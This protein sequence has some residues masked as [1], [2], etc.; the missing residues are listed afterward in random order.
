MLQRVKPNAGLLRVIAAGM[1]ATALASVLLL[2]A[3]P[4]HDRVPGASAREARTPVLQAQA[5][6]TISSRARM[7]RVP[8]SFLGLSTEYWAMPVFA[9]H[10]APLQR[11]LSLVHVRGD[12][13]LVLRIGGDSADHAFWDPRTRRM[14]RWVFALTPAWLRQTRILV[15]RARV[16]LILDLNLITG[17]PLRAA[18]WARAAEANLPG[19]AIAGF[20]IGNEADIYSRRYWLAAMSR[21]RLSA[22][23]IPDRLSASAY[24]QDFQSYARALAQVAPGVPLVGPAVA[25]PVRDVSWISSLLASEHPRLG[26]VSAHRYPFSACAHP[27]SEN[28]PT[29][30]RLLSERATAGLA[31]SV[32]AAARHAHRAG[33]P[34]RLTELNS[35]TC[36]GRPGVSDTF[37]TALWA[38]DA[39]FEL[40][41]AGVDGANVHVRAGAANAAFTLGRRG[42]GA[43]P[44]LYG[45]ILFARALGPDAQLIGV[46]VHA[47]RSTHL[48]VWAVRV[49]GGALH[50]LLID[51]GDDPARVALRLP[52]TGPA[53]VE[54]LL[55]PSVGSR[56][57]V[58]LDGQQ[59]GRKGIWRGRPAK[60]TITPG[61]HGYEV[62]VAPVSAALL[63]V[64]LRPGALAVNVG[65]DRSTQ[66]RG[67]NAATRLVRTGGAPAQQNLTVAGR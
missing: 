11:V 35:V 17:S 62:T 43:R 29:I 7:R 28:Y 36:G 19:G 13:P 58:T 34:F 66:P 51:K 48:K 14:S 22:G 55:A 41:Q 30:E 60:Q 32:A 50:V 16:R 42:L 3:V 67:M 37:A 53:T 24:T 4:D 39:L 57:A 61:V 44:L 38:P 45:L 64:H 25:N 52:A 1:T 18:Q 8:D 26:T 6:L 47:A 9:R 23:L 56:S 27:G 20:E 54:R 5:K 59:L 65:P 10:G 31:Q 12:G 15:R 63:S 46:Q 21:T 2:L 40:L 49:R 33:L